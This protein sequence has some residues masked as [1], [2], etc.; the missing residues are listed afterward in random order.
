MGIMFL[1]VITYRLR[2]ERLLRILAADLLSSSAGLRHIGDAPN[3][4][5]RCCNRKSIPARVLIQRARSMRNLPSGRMLGRVI[6]WRYP[7]NSIGAKN[8]PTGGGSSALATTK[9]NRNSVTFLAAGG[10]SG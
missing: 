4:I 3:A 9:S 10:V 1:G 2:L 5:T 6:N 7:M 8:S